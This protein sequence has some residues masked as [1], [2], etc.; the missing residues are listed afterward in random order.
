MTSAEDSEFEMKVKVL[1]DLKQATMNSSTLLRM[2][3]SS[4]D[5]NHNL[6]LSRIESEEPNK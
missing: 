4:L 1:P 6:P 3:S 5:K 2:R